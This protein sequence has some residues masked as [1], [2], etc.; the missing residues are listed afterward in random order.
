MKLA[1][2]ET[3][4]EE[5]AETALVMA[6]RSIAEVVAAIGAKGYSVKGACVLLSSGR[7]LPALEK[8]LAA[9][10][11]I[12]TAEG[13]FFRNA[14]RKGCESCGL[15]VRAIREREVASDD[16]LIAELGKLVGPPWRQ[17]E[18]LCAAAALAML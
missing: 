4:I 15:K 13:E 2:A 12:H 6:S 9:H 10:P 7:P 5:C 18:K 3:F 16:P 14:V 11:L 17:D 1:D 8:I